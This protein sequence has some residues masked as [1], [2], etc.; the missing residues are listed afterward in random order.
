[1]REDKFPIAVSE[2]GLHICIDGILTPKEGLE[3]IQAVRGALLAYKVLTGKHID[4][5]GAR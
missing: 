1:M 5:G 4:D 2:S 3:L